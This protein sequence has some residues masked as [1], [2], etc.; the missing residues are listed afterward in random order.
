MRRRAVSTAPA[1][2]DA[3]TVQRPLRDGRGRTGAIV[4]LTLDR[5]TTQAR[6][7]H[8]SRRLGLLAGGLAA[9]VTLILSVLWRVVLAPLGRLGNA[10]GEIRAGRIGTRLRW[11][12]GD[13]LGV[14]ATSI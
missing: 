14:L 5:R 3:L 1:G 12:R 13:E 4:R 7:A 6:L 2:Q 10:M 9:M 11:R 8:V